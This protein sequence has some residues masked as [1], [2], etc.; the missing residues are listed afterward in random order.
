MTDFVS[1]TSALSGKTRKSERT[2]EAIL[3]AAQALF[4]EAG[5][6]RATVR[7]IAARAAIDP[8]MV[9]RYFGSKEALFARAT[10]FDLRLP[11]LSGTR[12]EQLGET[13]IQHFLDI[14]EGP[15]SNGSFT[16]LL[17]AAASN[18]EAAD[19]TR[20]VFAGQVLPMLAQVADRAELPVRAGLISSQLLGLALCR[21]VLKVPP[22]VAMQP[23][24][25]IANVA[26]VLQGYIT[27]ALRTG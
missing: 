20:K 15:S 16:I 27:G 23:A 14:W 2:R 18:E 19:K 6:E 22:V 24:Q 17:R 8:A 11:D 9:I 7:D 1:K 25:I 26:P 5:Y 13:L 10:V 12:P 4:A 3:K 21:Y